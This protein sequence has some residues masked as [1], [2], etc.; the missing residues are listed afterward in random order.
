MLPHLMSRALTARIALTRLPRIALVLLC[1]AAPRLAL[2]QTFQLSYPAG[3]NAGPITGRAFLF[4]ARTDKE[5]PRLQSGPDRESEPFF[6]VDVE[7]LPAGKAVYIDWN[8][9]GFPVP[10]FKEIPPGDY[11][12]QA[13]LLPYTRFTRSD[14]HTIWAH[15]DAGEGQR[16]NQSPGSLVS[17]VQKV[18]IDP[19]KKAMYTFSLT[20]K[21]P[22]VASPGET[23]W[24]KR[25]RITSKLASTFWG[26]D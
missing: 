12:A 7:A 9:P 11:Y 6:G 18:H 13:L 1:A 8:T 16:F 24:V 19:T 5:E 10:S 3:A 14:G 22:P 15:M 26:H 4:V 20:K 25:F 17:D 23:E 2:A 21:V